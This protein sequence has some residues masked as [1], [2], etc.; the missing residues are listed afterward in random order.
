[1]AKFQDAF[2]P[3]SGINLDDLVG[4]FAGTLNP[5]V[6]G[7]SAPIGSLYLR[8]NGQLFQKV[9]L[10]DTDWILFTQGV[11]ET[12]KISASDT[13]PGYLGAKLLVG[14]SLAKNITNTGANEKLVIDLA[15]IGTAGTYNRVTTNAKGQVISGS[16][17]AYLL[18]NQTI[19]VTGDV[20]GSGTTTLP[21][22][23]SNTGVS[24]GSYSATNLTV[25]TKGRI[26]SA[27]NGIAA[28]TDIGIFTSDITNQTPTDP[29]NGKIK[30]NNASQQ[31][32]TFL[33]LS[34]VTL[35][36]VDVS[37]YLDLAT[38]IGSIIRI[39]AISDSSQYQRW[40]IISVVSNTSWYTFGVV[41]LDQ[42]GID[43]ANGS[44]LSAFLGSG[45][46]HAVT[47]VAA[48][49]P[50][51]GFTISGSPITSTGNLVF[52]L[53]ND[54]AA[55]EGLTGAGIAV[56]T[57]ADTW[58]TRSIVGAL[59]RISVLNGDAVA[60]GPSIDISVGYVG[61][62]S[63]TT[64]GTVS[65]GTWN[66]T[67]I[68]TNVGGTGRSTIGSSGQVLGVNTTGNGLEYKTIANGTGIGLNFASGQIA[69]NNTGVTSIIGT[70]NQIAV[71]AAT[72]IVTLS[73]PQNI[74][75]VSSPTFAQITLGGNPTLPLQAATKQ[76]VDNA[77][78]GLTPKQSVRLSSTSNIAL[79][80]LQTLDGT[81]LS[82]GDRVLV[83]NQTTSAQN[84]IYVVSSGT[85]QRAPDMDTWGEVPGVFLFVE[86]GTTQAD[87]A[88]VS[89]ANQGGVLETT[90]ITWTQ[91]LSASDITAGTG[92][93]RVGNVIAIYDTG[94]AGT[95]NRVTTNAQGQV[96]AG[97]LLSYLTGNQNITLQGDIVGS[98]TTLITTTLPNIAVAG[99]YRS[100]TI[101][102]KGQFT[103]G[104][105][106]ATL[107][108]YGITDAQPLNSF[109][110]AQ[111]NLVINGL[112]V[113]NGN[114]A[115]TRSIAAGSNK[116][117]VVNADGVAGNPTID[118]V[119]TN[120]AL[121]NISGV[122]SISK[123]GTDLFSLGTAD[124]L[125]S[126]N[127]I[128]NALEYRTLTGTNITV[129]ESAGSINLSA[130]HNG[131]V[132]SVG[133]VSTSTGL[134]IT[135][136]AITSAGSFTFG[137]DSRINN[138][139]ALGST[140]GL[141][142]YTSTG[143]YAARTL[144]SPV[145]SI[146][147][148]NAQGDTGNIGIDLANIGTAGTYYSVVT[149]AFGRVT[150]G[151]TTLSWSSISG[152]PT[153]LVGYGITNAQPL[154]SF[155]T[156][157][158]ANANVGI[159]VKNGTNS[160]VRTIVAGSAKISV[161]NGDGVLG[162]P[163]IDLGF[164]GLN[165]LTDVSAA[166]PS[167]GDS[168]VWNGAIWAN[169]SVTP[170]LYAEHTITP[171]S[172]VATGVNS[173]ALGSGAVADAHDSLAFGLQSLSRRPGITQANG[174][175]ASQGDAQAGA[176][177]LRTS[178]INATPGVEMFF[179]GFNGAERLTMTSDTT[180]VWEVTVI[181]HRTDASGHAGFMLRGVVY[182]GGSLN[183]I[184]MLGTPSK[185]ILARSDVGYDAAVSAD[186]INGSLKITV[187]GASGQTIRWMALVKTTEITN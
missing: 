86:E 97:S 166:S 116:I 18:A 2:Q 3:E 66:G 32:S 20:A 82:T 184:M 79:S 105:N 40:E 135:G 84:G 73:T 148:T 180:W 164:V 25:D 174:R 156:S 102:T 56:R 127:S 145:G 44:E 21:L 178:T 47:S 43:F 11:G 173:I 64:L 67:L 24:A 103:T 113:K 133:A 48:T 87:T 13:N 115:I 132:T 179:D 101:N 8:S 72:G 70:A 129:T 137:L 144:V 14:S 158:S 169:G 122:L 88:W 141:V 185:E 62:T 151:S 154:N 187:K 171:I 92:L 117:T 17:M 159:V 131:T 36:G 30:W 63:I 80:G 153:T 69:I 39:Q 33:Y 28:N 10:P 93:T 1:M 6:L 26:I 128:G 71:S 22:V 119:E 77:V 100:V 165:N 111:A 112:Q 143:L 170:K 138:L 83:K 59:N 186:S 175:F 55:V 51:N 142:V 35:A 104:T 124:Q 147:I 54:L 4:I 49:A 150:S 12:V 149:D 38:Q 125:L 29:G 161:S 126:V 45:V 120:F 19:T 7:E 41:L 114:L 65:I 163:S 181:G 107:A 68:A 121:N 85:W 9:G 15:G 95:Y 136:S 57:A 60:A 52:T 106:P 61:Q 23:L 176:Y 16:S 50:V 118:A 99:T 46:T 96:T 152:T 58:A 89:T 146:S 53:A 108:G 130:D 27:T 168:L 172:P 34:D 134:S 91:F 139:L 78:Q 160:G 140:F 182:C 81:S 90:A 5:T 42:D 162:N 94:T 109:L 123:G 167:T 98:G 76:Y 183:S 31:S 75:S 110:T 157:I 74:S 37:N 155:L 177:I